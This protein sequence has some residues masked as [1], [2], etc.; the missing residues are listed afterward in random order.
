M[1]NFLCYNSILLLHDTYLHLCVRHCGSSNNGDELSLGGWI[2]SFGCS[3]NT[4]IREGALRVG[5]GAIRVARGAFDRLLRRNTITYNSRAPL[6]QTIASN[7]QQ[8]PTTTFGQIQHNH[9]YEIQLILLL[10]C[11]FTPCLVIIYI[12]ICMLES[13]FI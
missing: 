1:E 6:N 2:N 9:Y 13:P 4:S 10:L 8:N 11:C 12:Y 3:T 5:D 7:N